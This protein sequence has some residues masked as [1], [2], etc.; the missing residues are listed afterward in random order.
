M[1]WM[2]PRGLRPR[3]M[4]WVCSAYLHLLHPGGG[5]VGRGVRP[6]GTGR[7]RHRDLLCT[8]PEV[9]EA[10]LLIQHPGGMP[11]HSP[12]SKT[13]GNRYHHNILRPRRGRI[14][15]S[16]LNNLCESALSAVKKL[17]LK[18]RHLRLSASSYNVAKGEIVC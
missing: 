13:P 15:S 4:G 8:N 9:C 18:L 5:A 1:G 12:G 10:D 14:R 16:P 2:F 11:A 7:A 17:R 6:P 3:A